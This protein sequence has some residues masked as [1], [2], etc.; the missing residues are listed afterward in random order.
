MTPRYKILFIFTAVLI[1]LSV[2]GTEYSEAQNGDSAKTVS[3]DQVCGSNMDFPMSADAGDPDTNKEVKISI[4]VDTIRKI[5]SV[6]SDAPE[7]SFTLEVINSRG[8]I[9]ECV[10][11]APQY[12]SVLDNASK[13]SKLTAQGMFRA[14][15]GS[16]DESED[17]E[18]KVTM[19][20]CSFE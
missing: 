2:Y 9:L 17:E 11:N 14:V 13:G 12:K 5:P 18:C 19:Y 15:T 7:G 8:T 20:N 6:C 10:C 3:L 16:Y 4:E 1:S